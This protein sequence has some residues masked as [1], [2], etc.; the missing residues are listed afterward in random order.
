MIMVSSWTPLSKWSSQG[1]KLSV[2]GAMAPVGPPLEPPIYR[3]ASKPHG[4][5]AT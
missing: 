5:K 4:N 1:A 2:T 3:T